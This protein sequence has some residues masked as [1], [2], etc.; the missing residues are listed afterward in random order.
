[1]EEE[2]KKKNQFQETCLDMS[3]FDDTL[4][5]TLTSQDKM[6]GR[7]DPS[8]QGLQNNQRSA[9]SKE[10]EQSYYDSKMREVMAWAA[11]QPTPNGHIGLQ[12]KA[13]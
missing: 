8:N 7:R 9:T 13:F 4:S 1:M 3:I 11:T 2:K 5:S 12:D 10:E 6:V